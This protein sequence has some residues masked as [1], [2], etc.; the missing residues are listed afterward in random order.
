M[1]EV[2]NFGRPVMFQFP[3]WVRYKQA[4]ILAYQIMNRYR[5]KAFQFPIWVRY[6]YFLA[7]CRYTI[8]WKSFNSLYG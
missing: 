1:I 7:T 3:I 5:A 8:T 2:F 6:R 4:L